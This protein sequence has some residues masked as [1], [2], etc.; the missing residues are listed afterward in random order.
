MFIISIFTIFPPVTGGAT[1]NG[2]TSN[3]VNSSRPSSRA[4]VQANITTTTASRAGN[5]QHIL[6][7]PSSQT[8]APPSTGSGPGKVSRLEHN[9]LLA[10]IEKAAAAGDDYSDEEST[11]SSQAPPPPAPHRTPTQ[12]KIPSFRTTNVVKTNGE[13]GQQAFL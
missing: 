10:T 11:L 2:S 3:G 7:L 9:G 4:S 5:P 6:G 8:P 12:S 13:F 1:T